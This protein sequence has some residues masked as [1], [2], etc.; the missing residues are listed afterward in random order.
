MNQISSNSGETAAV[1]REDLSTPNPFERQMAAS[2]ASSIVRAMMW[3]HNNALVDTARE[4]IDDYKTLM[5]IGLE[6][7][8]VRLDTAERALSAAQRAQEANHA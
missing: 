5:E 3:I 8:Q 6:A 2:G 7:I 1:R 4:D